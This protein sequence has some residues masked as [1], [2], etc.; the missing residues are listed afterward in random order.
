[1]LQGQISNIMELSLSAF[2]RILIF[3]LGKYMLY[4]L[5]SF[6]LNGYSAHT[7]LITMPTAPCT[8]WLVGPLSLFHEAD[9][10]YSCSAEVKN[11]WGCTCSSSYALMIWCWLCHLYLYSNHVTSWITS[12]FQVQI[13][14]WQFFC[15]HLIMQCV[16]AKQQ[17]VGSY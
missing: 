17:K 5:I 10:S 14:R 15:L 3:R 1:M 12:F 7:M 6:F 11:E 4:K 8:Q 9:H 16:T 13:E 2:I